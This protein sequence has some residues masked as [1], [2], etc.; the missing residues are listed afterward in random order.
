MFSRFGCAVAAVLVCVATV[1]CG[2]PPTKE[3]DL[4]R[5]AIEAARSAQAERYAPAELAAART[6]ID[7]SAAAALNR[8]FKLA[9]N[10]ALDSHERAKTASS[11]ATGA[12]RARRERLD[13]SLSNV[14]STLASARTTV[15]AAAR[16]RSSRR[17]AGR[18][19]A[20]L[21]T[22]DTDLQKARAL[23]SEDDLDGA[24]L[25]LNGVSTRIAQIVG[26][27]EPTRAPLAAKRTKAPPAARKS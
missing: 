10:H 6:A 16:V 9:L 3:M 26:A 20:A 25:L 13:A 5:Q 2:T 23:V 15:G 7:K 4:A 11:A 12:H 14:A 17:A 27:L 19:E 8:D 21:D 22:I 1:A 18:A 24:D